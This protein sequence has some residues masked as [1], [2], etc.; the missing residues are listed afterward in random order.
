M[1]IASFDP[2]KTTGFALM[3]IPN[4]I[5]LD[6]EKDASKYLIDCGAFTLAQG[7]DK[8]LASKLPDFVV[9]EDYRLY[10]DKIQAKSGDDLEEVGALNL[11]KEYAMNLRIPYFMQMPTEKKC[12]N[13]KILNQMNLKQ[14]LIHTNDAITH[15]CTFFHFKKAKWEKA[16]KDIEYIRATMGFEDKAISNWLNQILW[17]VALDVLKENEAKEIINKRSGYNGS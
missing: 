9:I 14:P 11:I 1:L 16:I 2:G 13:I 15:A 5:F 17:E 6:P 8:Y 4:D 10:G 12:Y 3:Q 7:I